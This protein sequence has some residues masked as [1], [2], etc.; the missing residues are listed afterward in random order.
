MKRIYN[1]RPSV[2]DFRDL[3]FEPKLDVAALPSKV[4]L[5]PECPE[6]YDQGQL[7]SCTANAIGGAFEFELLRQ[8]ITDFMPSRLFIYY[9]ERALEGTVR[10]D[11]GAQI[12]DGIKVTIKQGVCP[13]TE[14]PYIITKFKNKPTRKC[15]TDA[16]KNIVNQYQNIPQVLLNLK[17]CLAQGSPFVFGISVYSSF[18]SQTVADTGIVPMPDK[19]EKCLGG[20]AVCCVGYDDDSQRFIVRNSWG[21]SWGQKGYFTIPYSYLTNTG[22]ASDFW[23]INSVS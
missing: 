7:G 6:V 11:S 20:H 2:P 3:K 14:W 17:S 15:Y 21:A 8:K 5:R 1:W 22:L 18:E 9:N 23:V 13:E 19:S 12:R 16:L 10:T 4:D